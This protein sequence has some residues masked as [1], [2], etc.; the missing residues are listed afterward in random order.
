MKKISS[1]HN[2][3][4]RKEIKI[5][6]SLRHPNI[7][8][9]EGAVQVEHMVYI[10]LEYADNGALFFFINPRTGM[11]EKF[12]FKFFYQ[13]ALA[14]EYLHSKGIMHRDIKPENILLDRNYDAK[15]CDFGWCTEHGAHLPDD[16]SICGTYE[17][18]PPEIV[19]EKSHNKEVDIWA[20]GVLLYELIHGRAP[21][22]AESLDDIKDRMKQTEITFKKSLS[23]E[24]KD[25]LLKLLKFEPSE[26]ITLEQVFTH[27]FILKHL[28]EYENNKDS[29]KYIPPEPEWDNDLDIYL[30]GEMTNAVDEAKAALSAYDD[31]HRFEE[32]L[33][34][35]PVKQQI[36]IKKQLDDNKI[37]S[38]DVEKVFF[39][40]DESGNLKMRLQMKDR[41]QPMRGNSEKKNSLAR[42]RGSEKFQ[43]IVGPNSPPK[44]NEDIGLQAGS[45][46][47]TK[48]PVPGDKK[49]ATS[50][51]VPTTTGAFGSS[52]GHQTTEA[53]TKRKDPL[54]V[55]NPQSFQALHGVNTASEPSK[56]LA[57]PPKHDELGV[58]A[59]SSKPRSG[60]ELDPVNP[61]RADLGA[62]K[63]QTQP[64]VT[65]WDKPPLT[66]AQST[67]SPIKSPYPLLQESPQQT[68]PAHSGP[69]PL[70]APTLS[71]DTTKAQ[72]LPQP[73]R[74]VSSTSTGGLTATSGTLQPTQLPN[75]TL[76]AQTSYQ[77][78]SVLTPLKQQQLYQP[79]SLSTQQPNFGSTNKLPS[80]TGSTDKPDERRVLHPLSVNTDS[81]VKTPGPAPAMPTLKP[82][83]YEP[84]PL[85]SQQ[86]QAGQSVESTDYFAWN[87]SNPLK[88]FK[89]VFS[90]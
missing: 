63:L 54:N 13:T 57:G 10:M 22:T 81:A 46:D 52:L 78:T 7:I 82:N 64:A 14:L 85:N 50:A 18:M 26:R 84:S 71:V 23:P 44:M 59:I 16:E 74:I 72:D 88:P 20:I 73:I 19:Y 43:R 17:Y 67:S 77:A 38:N 58:Q 3:N 66:S 49:P 48:N 60:S 31:R 2:T 87:R 35:D 29:F 83:S 55:H 62:L 39:L 47:S 9:F 27:P 41:P 79:D 6:Q 30:N 15:L 68:K 69:A 42:A 51:A 37:N 76:T 56:Q 40:R 89:T 45:L 25:L 53:Q 33:L 61:A 32:E 80:S 70:L 86:T 8:R 5:H 12:A 4:L 1:V 11:P 34:S 36:Y 65:P 28:D 90:I 24:A 21:Y 75:E